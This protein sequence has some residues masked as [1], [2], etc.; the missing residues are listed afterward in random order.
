M[1]ESVMPAWRS[2]LSLTTST[3]PTSTPTAPRSHTDGSSPSTA[4]ASSVP[5]NGWRHWK[6]AT[7]RAGATSCHTLLLSCA[8]A[9]P[10]I[11]AA[12]GGCRQ[13]LEL[14]CKGICPILTETRAI[15]GPHTAWPGGLSA[16]RVNNPRPAYGRAPPLYVKQKHPSVREARTQHPGYDSTIIVARIHH[17]RSHI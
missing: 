3:S 8:P 9:T 1:G 11:L 14:R 13:P 16:I 15:T 10:P 6:L 5:T 12:A 17:H 2:C 4:N 7:W